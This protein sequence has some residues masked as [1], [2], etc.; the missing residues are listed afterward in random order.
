MRGGGGGGRGLAHIQ[1]IFSNSDPPKVATLE[2]L[3]RMSWSIIRCLD[4]VEWGWWNS[5]MVE[6]WNSGIVEWWNS[7]MVEWWNSGM[8]MVEWWNGGIVEWWNNRM[9][10]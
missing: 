4:S 8:R 3:I 1:S 6:W 10:E 2:L 9:V 7:G 5:G